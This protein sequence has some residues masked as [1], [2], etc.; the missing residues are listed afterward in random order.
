MKS[1]L[2]VQKTLI[3]KSTAGKGVN[4]TFISKEG[5]SVQVK[6]SPIAETQLVMAILAT[7]RGQL[8]GDQFQ[9]T[10]PPIKALD[11]SAFVIDDHGGLEILIQPG[12]AIHIAFDQKGLQ[13]LETEIQKLTTPTQT[14]VPPRAL[15]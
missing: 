5:K 7:A 14:L 11:F 2:V 12:A 9:L 4:L 8:I 15:H 1:P 13:K 3:E 6:L 10:M